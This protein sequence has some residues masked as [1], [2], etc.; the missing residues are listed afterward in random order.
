MHLANIT[1]AAQQA[2]PRTPQQTTNLNLVAFI[3]FLLVLVVIVKNRRRS[4]DSEF[5]DCPYC[6]R[7]IR[8]SAKICHHCHR[9][10]PVLARFTSTVAQPGLQR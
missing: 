9:R 2:S 6:G 5:V 7:A 4:R 8:Y 1:L 3:V 10:I